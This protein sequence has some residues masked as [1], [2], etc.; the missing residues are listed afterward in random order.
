MADSDFEVDSNVTSEEDSEEEMEVRPWSCAARCFTFCLR[1]NENGAL[2]GFFGN[3]FRK[4][5][6]KNIIVEMYG[7]R[8]ER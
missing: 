2:L 7:N 3:T 4:V 8:V 1:P 6:R 5:N